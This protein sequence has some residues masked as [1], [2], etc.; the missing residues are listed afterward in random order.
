M[1]YWNFRKIITADNRIRIKNLV[2]PDINMKDDTYNELIEKA[3][4]K[5]IN[6]LYIKKG[7]TLSLGKTK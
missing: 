5:K 2:M 1:P 6:V 7:D 4:L 3:K